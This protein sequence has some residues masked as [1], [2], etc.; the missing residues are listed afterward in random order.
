[1]TPIRRTCEKHDNETEALP[2]SSLIYLVSE[3]T[4]DG[5]IDPASRNDAPI[6]ALPAAAAAAGR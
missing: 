2:H 3:S 1:M 6:S 4:L 5:V